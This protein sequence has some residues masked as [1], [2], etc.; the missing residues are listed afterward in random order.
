[1]VTQGI[2]VAHNL[3]TRFHVVQSAGRRSEGLWWPTRRYLCVPRPKEAKA[4]V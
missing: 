4:S 1:V 2:R 3:P